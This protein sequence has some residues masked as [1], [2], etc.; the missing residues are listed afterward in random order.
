MIP[1]GQISYFHRVLDFLLTTLMDELNWTEIL[2]NRVRLVQPRYFWREIPADFIRANWKR[3][4]LLKELLPR[5]AFVGFI[6]NP[7][8]LYWYKFVNYPFCSIF[9][10]N[11]LLYPSQRPKSNWRGLNKAY[12]SPRAVTHEL[13]LR[14]EWFEFGSHQHCTM[15]CN[16]HQPVNKFWFVL[17]LFRTFDLKISNFPLIDF[18][19]RWI[20]V[21]NF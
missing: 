16:N 8:P 6:L 3:S 11:F 15:S 4:R 7:R 2:C 13:I 14:D 19:R 1:L 17:F 12:I 10:L 9:F 5:L 20:Q 18:H 21:I